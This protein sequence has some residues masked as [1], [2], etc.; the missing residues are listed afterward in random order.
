MQRPSQQQTEH[1]GG[2]YHQGNIHNHGGF[3]HGQPARSS[4]QQQQQQQA[5]EPSTPK[6]LLLQGDFAPDP[7]LASMWNGPDSLTVASMEMERRNLRGS[8][9]RRKSLGNT[10]GILYA[11]V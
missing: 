5:S 2:F 8:T 6:G 11:G 7:A 10:S 1:G 9:Q 4:G 3:G